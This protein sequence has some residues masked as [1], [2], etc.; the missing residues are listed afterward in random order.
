MNA[1]CSTASDPVSYE[2]Y[3]SIDKQ[4][5]KL[6]GSGSVTFPKERNKSGLVNY[7][8]VEWD[9]EVYYEVIKVVFPDIDGSFDTICNGSETC[10]DYPLAIGEI[11][12]FGW[13]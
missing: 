5:F 12:L 8:E 4:N 3:G 10:K 2:V 9:N 1:E 7:V 11:E 13:C 6:M